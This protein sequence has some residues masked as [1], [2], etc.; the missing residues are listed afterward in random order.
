MMPHIAMV[1]SSKNPRDMMNGNKRKAKIG[2]LNGKVSPMNAW[3][4]MPFGV[5]Y[6]H[7][8]NV[9]IS[10]LCLKVTKEAPNLLCQGRFFSHPGCFLL[11]MT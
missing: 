2:Y 7:I 9:G 5:F 6:Q 3:S 4:V 11:K 1:T 8:F 10:T